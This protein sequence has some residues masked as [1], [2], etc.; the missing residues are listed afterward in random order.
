MLL[1]A[2]I[3]DVSLSYLHTTT[4]HASGERESLEKSVCSGRP[5]AAPDAQLPPAT[6][7]ANGSVNVKNFNGNMS[8][9]HVIESKRNSI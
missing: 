4:A 1:P 8:E 2:E 6:V 3:L 5:V 9:L 7:R